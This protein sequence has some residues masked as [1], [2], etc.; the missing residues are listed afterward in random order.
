M[1]RLKYI[2]G[3][4]GFG[5]LTIFMTHFKMFD[6]HH[7]LEAFSIFNEVFYGD[8][9]LNLFMTASAFGITCSIYSNL[10]KGNTLRQLVLKRYLRL[11]LPI[12]FILFITAAIYYGGLLWNNEAAELGGN[13]LLSNFYNKVSISGL[14]K[15]IF[16]SP[17][18]ILEGW[19][20]PGW[21]LKYIFYGT[22]MT[23]GF[24]F[25]TDGLK[26]CKT[27]LICLFFCVLFFF[28][29]PRMVFVILGYVLYVY[30]HAKKSNKYDRWIT[31][32]AFA[33]YFTLRAA[34]Y[35]FHFHRHGMVSYSL[36]IFLLIA[37]VHSSAIQNF[38]TT[39][40]LLWLGKISMSV[41]L[42]HFVL[43]CS[44]TSWLYIMLY[45]LNPLVASIINLY[46]TIAILLLLSWVFDKYIEQKI[47]IPL[48]KKIIHF[49]EN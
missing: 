37:I 10:Q 47:S 14:V 2:D 39:K 29:D 42:L 27:Y 31:I 22:F 30:L 45:G 23:I 25:G 8:M 21:M 1:Q 6:F 35:Y 11:S 3:L 17:F 18:G 33:L 24:V 41:Y 7:P 12:T 15:A 26:P 44:F 20:S 46:V 5:C 49:L 19:L 48:T 32:I 34:T 28:I 43:L 16:L 36:A 4:K 13:Q 40:P 9:F 38:F